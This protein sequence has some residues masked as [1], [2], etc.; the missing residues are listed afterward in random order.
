M[1]YGETKGQADSNQPYLELYF[2]PL[3][4]NESIFNNFQQSEFFKQVAIR[5]YQNVDCTFEIGNGEKVNIPLNLNFN[6]IYSSQHSLIIRPI[7]EENLIYKTTTVELFANGS[8]KFLVPLFEFD[9]TT[10]PKHYKNS[11]VIEYLENTYS[12]LETVNEANF[13][14]G[15]KLK[16]PNIVTIR[17]DTDFV[18]HIR[19]IDGTELIYI[20]MI[21]IAKYRAVLNDFDFKPNNDFGFRARLTNTWRKFVFFDNADYLEK[22]KLYNIPISP[23]NEVE[24][25]KFVN[26][27]FYVMDINEQ[28]LYLTISR[29]ILTAI[30][31]PDS[32]TIQF[33]EI[34]NS[35]LN[36]FNSTEKF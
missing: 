24:V 31:L 14:M 10:I 13:I 2:F 4:Y 35:G 15:G 30:G 33:L 27:N 3:P 12:P 21:V 20:L 16:L 11:K 9:L 7:K 34:I 19:M 26:G 18:R 23:K 36:R 22:I 5:F 25:P 8:F 1:D 28:D 17:K 32:S 6:S 29:I